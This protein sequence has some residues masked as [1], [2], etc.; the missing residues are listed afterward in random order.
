M[1]A[2]YS[3]LPSRNVADQIASTLR[4]EIAAGTWGVG[5]MLPAE[6]QL[7]ERFGVSRP[8]CREAL[9][10]LQSEGLLEIQRRVVQNP[11]LGR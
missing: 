9:R 8:S 6:H 1:T 4:S 10:I 7:M 11:T 3:L 2:D 5:Q